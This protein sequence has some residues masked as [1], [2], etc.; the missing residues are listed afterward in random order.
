MDVTLKSLSKPNTGRRSFMWK[1]G[2]AVSAAL[3]SAVPGMA[4]QQDQSG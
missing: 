3:A 4:K 2:A 1:T